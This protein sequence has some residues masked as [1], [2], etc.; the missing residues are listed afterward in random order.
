MLLVAILLVAMLHAARY[1]A[2]CCSSPRGRLNEL[3]V[4]RSRVPRRQVTGRQVLLDNNQGY[5]LC[6]AKISYLLI[7]TP[8]SCFRV[9]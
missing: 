2:A 3:H 4:I 9:W 6:Y 7:F 8:T 5:N 1:H